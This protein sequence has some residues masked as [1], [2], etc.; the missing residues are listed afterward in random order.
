MYGYLTAKQLAPGAYLLNPLTFAEILKWDSTDLDQVSLNVVIETGS[1]G[2]LF[3]T[4]LIVSTRIP[5]NR[6]YL[7][8]T[9]DKLGRIPERKAVEVKIFDNIP[10][11]QYDT[12]C[13]L[14]QQWYMK[15][16]NCMQET[17]IDRQLARS[18]D[19]S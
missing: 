2:V 19:E 5:A 14:Y 4:R 1:F 15:K 6:I 12:Q 3:G 10:A 16:L 7:V 18:V 13:R 9:P 8:T 11:N 17:L